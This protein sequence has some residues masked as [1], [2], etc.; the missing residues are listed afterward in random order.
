MTD[1]MIPDNNDDEKSLIINIT[2]IRLCNI[3]EDSKSELTLSKIHY[4]NLSS[5]WIKDHMWNQ[6]WF[7]FKK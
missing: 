1:V 4:N 6:L 7:Y 3:P 5:Q 2:D